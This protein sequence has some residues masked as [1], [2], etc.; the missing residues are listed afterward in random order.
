MNF[1]R[2]FYIWLAVLSSL[3]ALTLIVVF[4]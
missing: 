1:D 2:V 4:L 3:T